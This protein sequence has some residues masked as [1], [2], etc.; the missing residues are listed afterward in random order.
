MYLTLT[1]THLEI[2]FRA[3]FLVTRVKYRSRIYAGKSDCFF[4]HF[5]KNTQ[6]RPNI[7]SDLKTCSNGLTGSKPV[8]SVTV[9]S[10]NNPPSTFQ[11]IV[12]FDPSHEPSFCLIVEITF[13][14]ISVLSRVDGILFCQWVLRKVR[15]LILLPTMFT[16]PTPV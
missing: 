4:Y 8:Q 7:C 16:R 13:E 10:H 11:T 15:R 9:R 1:T 2:T 14:H 12:F 6:S 5:V 3:S